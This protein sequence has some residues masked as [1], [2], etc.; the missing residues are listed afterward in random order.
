MK[1]T[2]NMKSVKIITVAGARPN[3]MKVAPFLRA[4]QKYEN[5]ISLLVHTGQHYDVNMSDIFFQNLQM[6]QPDYHLGVGSGGIVEQTAKIM[7]EFEKVILKE[8]PDL[9]VVVGDVTSTIS[10]ALTAVRHGIKVAHIEAGLRS[11]DRTMPEEINR[12]L[13]DQ[14][15]DFLFVTEQSGVDNLLKEGVANEKIFFAGN[16]M[17]DSFV[18]FEKVADDSRILQQLQLQPGKYAAVTL[19]R[20][21]T[22]DSKEIFSE[23]YERKQICNYRFR[24]NTGRNN[25]HGIAM[26]YY[27]K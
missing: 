10:C 27:K 8:M 18:Q 17:I 5:V 16:L 23:T 14:I 4:L 25:F 21:S 24:R 7:V 3:F 26:H 1:E 19:H 11:F 2:K 6:K 12:I 15:S 13:T 9:V 20:P 22:V